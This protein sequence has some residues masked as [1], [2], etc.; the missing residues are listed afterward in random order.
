MGERWGRDGGEM[1]E[2]WEEGRQRQEIKLY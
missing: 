2:R 1:G